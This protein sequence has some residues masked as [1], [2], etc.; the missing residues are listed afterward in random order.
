MRVIHAYGAVGAEITDESIR[1]DLN[2]ARSGPVQLRINSGGGDV[3]QGNAIASL[4]KDYAGRI[5][6]VVDGLAASAASY[7][8]MAANRV[9]MAQGSFIM[10]HEPSVSAVGTFEEIR[11]LSAT[12]EKIRDDYAAVYSRRSGQPLEEV[13]GMM[14]R[15]TWFS[16][17][18]A[19]ELGFADEISGTAQRLAASLPAGYRHVPDAVRR[20]AGDGRKRLA[21]A[22]AGIALTGR[23]RVGAKPSLGGEAN[24]LGVAIRV[25]KSRKK[26]GRRR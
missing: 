12:L 1:R 18:E 9:I 8:A 23:S 25:Q 10:I 6:A 20:M 11:S 26:S 5:E 4:L 22:R 19:V 17:A 14:A 3:F 2:R 21:H 16:A 24:R 15:E 7:I 13:R